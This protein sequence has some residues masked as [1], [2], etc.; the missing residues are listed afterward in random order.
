MTM[1][2]FLKKLLFCPFQSSLDQAS[3]Q[4]TPSL[5]SSGLKTQD[6]ALVLFPTYEGEKPFSSL[7]EKNTFCVPLKKRYRV[8]QKTVSSTHEVAL[9][10]ADAARQ[11][12]L[13]GG[14]LQTVILNGHGNPKSIELSRKDKDRSRQ[15]Y[16]DEKELKTLSL[17]D[18]QG[19]I[20]LLSCETGGKLRK[21]RQNVAQKLARTAGRTVIA[22]DLPVISL[23]ATVSR[24]GDVTYDF[25]VAKH[26]AN[27]PERYVRDPTHTMTFRPK[28]SFH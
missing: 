23:F 28:F 8:I 16:G 9:A 5:P 26:K 6:V 3:S 1:I 22:S 10:V 25:E 11:A 21:G 20:V 19:K 12:S 18:P 24:K 7:Q 27:R 2:S 4:T 14:R 13:G 17:I 15:L